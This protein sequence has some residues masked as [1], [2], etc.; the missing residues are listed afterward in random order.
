M[1]KTFAFLAFIL[2]ASFILGACAPAA[3]TQAPA[4]T[5]APTQPPQIKEVTRMVEGTPVVSTVVVTVEVT[6][7]PATQGPAPGSIQING[8]G[9][10]F[11]FPLYSRWFYEYAFVD[12][13]VQVQLPVHRLRRR[14][15]ADHRQDRRLWRVRTPS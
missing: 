15:Q 10:T 14:H 8:A 4:A 5:M 3:A 13:T 6:Q 2:I 7:P 11:P 12:P 9:A 1:R